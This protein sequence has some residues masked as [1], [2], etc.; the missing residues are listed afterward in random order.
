M[1][2]N[3][4]TLTGNTNTDPTTN[5]LGTTEGRPERALRTAQTLHTCA[6]R[7][8]APPLQSGQRSQPTGGKF[9]IAG[10]A[11]RARPESLPSSLQTQ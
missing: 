9:Q 4:W 7:S 1:D 2:P 5:F 6:P 11:T 8:P 10:F 3:L